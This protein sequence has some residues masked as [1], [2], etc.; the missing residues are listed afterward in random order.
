MWVGWGEWDSEQ[1]GKKSE[2]EE[3]R[4]VKEAVHVSGTL[5]TTEKVLGIW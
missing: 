3:E 2:K 5:S 1:W 4:I